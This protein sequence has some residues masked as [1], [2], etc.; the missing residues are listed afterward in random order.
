MSST[1]TLEIETMAQAS[2]E[3]VFFKCPFG[4]FASLR[5]GVCPKCGELLMKVGAP[6]VLMDNYDEGHAQADTL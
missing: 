2:T 4:G 1:G 5:P 6:P 3:R